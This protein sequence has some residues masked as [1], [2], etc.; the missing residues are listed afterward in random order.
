MEQSSNRTPLSRLLLRQVLALGYY[1]G[2]DSAL[3]LGLDD[4]QY[5][6]QALVDT[7]DATCRVF[8]IKRLAHTAKLDWS[9]LQFA[10]D[11]V[12]TLVRWWSIRD[13]QGET[14]DSLSRQLESA[15]YDQRFVGLSDPS[16]SR[17]LDTMVM[18]PAMDA[19][20]GMGG[21]SAA[22]YFEALFRAR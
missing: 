16:M 1:D 4:Q 10:P 5:F 21:D 6:L 14:F 18:T 8:E 2:V 12:S 3:A 15:A 22:K 20:I 19:A 11:R 17:G 7:S 9:H 13:D